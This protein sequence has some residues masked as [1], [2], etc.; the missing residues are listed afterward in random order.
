VFLGNDLNEMAGLPEPESE[1]GVQAT[2]SA[3]RLF[4]ANRTLDERWMLRRWYVVQWARALAVRAANRSRHD[5]LVEPVFTIMDRATPLEPARRAFEQAVDRLVAAAVRF[6]FTPVVVVIPDRFQVEP[7]I[8]R[9]K[10][11]TSR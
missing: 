6:R 7:R 9:D 10:A 8:L 3:V 11:N 1:R 2:F 5:P 4:A